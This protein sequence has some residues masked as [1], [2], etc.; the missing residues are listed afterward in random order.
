[1][2][3]FPFNGSLLGSNAVGL[4][5]I[6]AQDLFKLMILSLKVVTIL[7]GDAVNIE[8]LT[9]VVMVMN[10]K[11]MKNKHYA[12]K[13]YASRGVSVVD[14]EAFLDAGGKN[15]LMFHHVGPG[16]SCFSPR[17]P[18]GFNLGSTPT[19]FPATYLLFSHHVDLHTSTWFST[20]L[21]T[22][23]VTWQKVQSH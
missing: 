10:E 14:L 6:G 8:H 3:L 22:S 1:M 2:F 11:T 7:E 18:S 23:N 16:P 20:P 15:C 9:S 17:L 5:T 19:I 21:L 13:R 12:S 4:P